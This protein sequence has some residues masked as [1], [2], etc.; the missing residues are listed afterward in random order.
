MKRHPKY[1]IRIENESRIENVADISVS[2]AILWAAGIIS[3]VIIL[4]IAGTLIMVSPLRTLLPGYMKQSERSA[5][6]DNILRLD[7]ILGV[8]ENN[9][10]YLDNVL[11]ALDTGR[12]PS[13]ST[14]ISSN[15]RELSPDSL[16][17]PSQLEQKFVSAMEERERFNI[18]VLAPLAADGI[19][20]SPLGDNALYS[21][22]SRNS[23]VGKVI[24][25]QNE[26]V[27]CVAD[28]TVIASY[29]SPAEKGNVV[30]IQHAR[31]FVTRCSH[32]GT[33]MVDTGDVVMSGQILSLAPSPDAY[34]QRILEIRMWHNGLPLVPYQYIGSHDSHAAKEI[35][36]EA[37]R[38]R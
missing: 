15:I 1:R 25:P 8:Y 5:T 10:Q 22:A 27:R 3:V 9:Q 20:F 16:L 23:E 24:M 13:D 28:G 19:M 7:S 34:G 37:P 30:I 2:P 32:L 26:A 4:L 35:P 33:P 38:G 12:I 6:E 17:P 11:R 18:S 36:Y 29:Y 21:V 31:G 14:A